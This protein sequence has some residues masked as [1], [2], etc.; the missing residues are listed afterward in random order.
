MKIT[1]VWTDIPVQ[2]SNGH[3]AYL[4][5]MVILGDEPEQVA[6]QV[7]Q[8]H[9]QQYTDDQILLIKENEIVLDPG[10]MLYLGEENKM[11]FRLRVRPV[12]IE[13]VPRNTGLSPEDAAHWSDEHLR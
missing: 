12:Y 8:R 9:A 2:T 6:G 11:S 5:P 10:G 4:I 1:R 13:I 3:P 7:I